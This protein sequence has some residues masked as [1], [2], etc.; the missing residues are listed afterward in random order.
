[1][2]INIALL[3]V[4]LLT[5]Y[6]HIFPLGTRRD[7]GSAGSIKTCSFSNVLEQLIA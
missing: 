5:S 3:Y 2:Y 1:M 4:R 7:T 6:G